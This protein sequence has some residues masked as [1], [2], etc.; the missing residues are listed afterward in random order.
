MRLSCGSLFKMNQ[1]QFNSSR[2]PGVSS[3]DIVFATLYSF[4][5]FFGVLGNAITIVRK[6]RSMHTTTN[7]LLMNLAVA[8]LLTLSFCPGF[9]EIAL[10]NLRLSSTVLGDIICKLFVGNAIVCIAFEASVLTLCVIAIERFMGIVKPFNN[11]WNLTIRKAYLA[12]GVV[13][14]LAVISSFPDM[15]W[16]NYNTERET[17]TSLGYPCTRSW[18]VQHHSPK[19]KIYVVSHSLVIIV[20]P[21]IISSFCYISIFT[22]LKCCSGEQ[23]PDE[24]IKKNTRKLLT[25]LVTLA[26]AFCVL[27]L[28]FAVFF[29]YV[30]SRDQNQ[31]NHRYSSLF[32][33][34]RVVR[35]LIFS[36]SFVNPLLYAAQSTNY[37]DVLRKTLCCKN[38]TNNLGREE[39]NLV[40]M[41]RRRELE[42]EGIKLQQDV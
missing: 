26:A 27:C 7:Y 22:S 36:N 24:T 37:R 19:M 38:N 41:G 23:P 9:Y 4:I 17:F 15:L 30:S 8:D 35:L 29:L 1:S 3:E 32:L 42:R 16:T 31:I 11:N 6:T 34:H 33:V 5:V 25:L 39:V 14:I 20:V 2:Y 18:A 28:P 13:W 10:K 40:P 21:S 12:I